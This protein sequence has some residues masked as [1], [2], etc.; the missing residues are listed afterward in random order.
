MSGVFFLTSVSAAPAGRRLH[1]SRFTPL[2]TAF[3]LASILATSGSTSVAQGPSLVVS[4]ASTQLAVGDSIRVEVRVKGSTSLWGVRL[5]LSFDPTILRVSDADRQQGGTQIERGAILRTREAQGQLWELVNR[6][7]NSRGTI[8]YAF[9]LLN[10]ARQAVRPITEEGPLVVVTVRGEA[11]GTS[12]VSFV[13]EDVEL[14]DKSGSAV[15]VALENG[16]V[17]VG[18][19]HRAYLPLTVSQALVGS[20]SAGQRADAQPAV[21]AAHRRS[22]AEVATASSWLSDDPAS[23]SKKPGLGTRLPGSAP[24]SAASADQNTPAQALAAPS[25]VWCGWV[26]TNPL[27]VGFVFT[28]QSVGEDEFL[29]ERQDP[30]ASFRQVGRL[31][32]SA[33]AGSTLVYRDDAIT[34]GTYYRYRVRAH[35]VSDGAYS[36]FSAIAGTPSSYD[37]LYFRIYYRITDCPDA[38]GHQVCVPDKQNPPGVN[39]TAIRVANALA[40]ARTSFMT[41]NGGQG[42]RDPAAESVEP[43]HPV[44]LIYEDGGGMAHVFGGSELTKFGATA[45]APE[46]MDGVVAG[47]DHQGYNPLTNSGEI[48]SWL[49]PL[50]ELFHQA[51][52]AYR[53]GELE[54]SR[55]WFLEGQARSIQ[56]KFCL[57]EDPSGG[58]CPSLD[59]EGLGI[60]SY[61]GEVNGYLANANRNLTEISYAAALFWTYVTE[62]YGLLRQEPHLGVDLIL[63]F[64]EEGSADPRQDGITTLNRALAAL[65]HRVTFEDVFKDFV[66]ANYA[67]ELTGAGVPEKY[68]YI[69]E[70]QPP[71]HY[72]PV[73]LDLDREITPDAAVD[74]TITEVASWGA[75]YYQFRPSADVPILNIEFRQDVERHVYYALLAVKNDGIAFER[76]QTDGDLVEV[77]PNDGYDRVVVIVA[78]LGNHANYRFAVNATRPVLRIL[79]PTEGRFAAAGDPAAPGKILLKVEVLSP[80]GA[81]APLEGIAA[82][83][84]DV[85]IGGKDL[86]LRMGRDLIAYSYIAGQ[87]WLTLRAPVQAADGDYDLTVSYAGSL[88]DTEPG[89]VH[90]AAG[91]EADSLI[92]IDRSLSMA[93]SGKMADAASAARL[94]VDSWNEGDQLGVVSFSSSATVDWALSPWSDANR[95]RALAAIDAIVPTW[96][97]SIGA[98]LRAAQGELDARGIADHDWALLVL[99]DGIE[100]TAPYIDDSLSDWADRANAGQHVPVVHTVAIG[101]DAERADLQNLS[102]T[103]GGLYLYAAEPAGAAAT[104]SGGVALAQANQDLANDLAEHFRTVSA[105]VAGLQQVYVARG[106]SRDMQENV[107]VV[108]T[109]RIDPGAS[110]A[111]FSVNWHLEGAQPGDP[112]VKLFGPQGNERTP[113]LRDP[114]H[115]VVYRIP[116]PAAGDWRLEVTLVC[117]HGEFC[118]QGKYLAEAAVKTALTA[119]LAIGTPAS[120]LVTG[121]AVPLLVTIT[122]NRAITGATVGYTIQT[123]TGTSASGRLYDDGRH[124]DGFANDGVYGVVFASTRDAGSYTVRFTA[125][126]QRTGGAAFRRVGT[127]SFN[128]REGADVDG[129]GLPDGYERQHGLDPNRNDAGEDPDMDGLA[130]RYEYMHHTH[131]RDDDTDN[132][133]ENDGSE[134]D[135]HSDPLDRSDDAIKAPRIAAYPGVAKAF[136]R[137]SVPAGTDHLMLYRSTS[138]DSGY[139]RV[140]SDIR[141]TGIY[142]DAGL[143]NGTAYWYRMVAVGRANQESAPSE[144]SSTTARRDSVPPVGS[145]RINGGARTT[146]SRTVTLDLAAHDPAEPQVDVPPPWDPTSAASGVSEMMLANSS[147]FANAQWEPYARSKTWTIEPRRGRA[148]VF[149]RYRD[150]G[151]NESETMHASIEYARQAQCPRSGQVQAVFLM[152]TS[153]SMD[154]EYEALCERVDQVV[155]DLRGQG[156]T[157]QYDTLGITQNKHCATRNVAALFPTS[158][159]NTPEDWGQAVA[160]VAALYSW[161]EGY[162]RLLVPMSDEGPQDGDPVQDPGADRDVLEAAITSAREQRVIVSPVLGTVYGEQGDYAVTVRLATELAQGTGGQIFMSTAPASDLAAGIGGL[163]GA[164]ACTPV[165]SGVQP[166]CDVTEETVVRVFGQNLLA[167]STVQV[168]GKSARDAA[169]GQDPEHISFRIPTGLAH[170]TYDVTVSNPGFGEGTLPAALTVGP[171]SQRCEGSQPDDIWTPMWELQD[172]QMDLLVANWTFPGELTVGVYSAQGGVLAVLFDP[173][174]VE[175]GRVAV[176]EGAT[177]QIAI[178]LGAATPNAS[179]RLSI[180][181]TGSVT[182]R[183]RA[184]FRGA[185]VVALPDFGDGWERTDGVPHPGV[186]SDHGIESSPLLGFYG[187]WQNL[188]GPYADTTWYFYVTGPEAP[189]QVR[190]WSEHPH[191]DG[192]GGM[193]WITP[194]DVAI[195]LVGPEP[196]GFYHVFGASQPQQGWWGLRIRADAP[197]APGPLHYSL[198]RV[199]PPSG[200]SLTPDY[201]A[202]LPRSM[203]GPPC[204]PSVV[205]DPPRKGA[206]NS[207]VVP[208]DIVVSDVANLYGAEVHLSFDP[209]HLEVVDAT[210][211]VTSVITP[212][213]FPDPGEGRRLVAQN[214]VDNAQGTIDYAVTLLHPAPAAFGDGVLARVLFRVKQGGITPV[215]FTGGKLDE[216]PVPPLGPRQIPVQARGALVVG[217]DCVPGQTGPGQIDGQVVLQGRNNPAGARVVAPPWTHPQLTG[218]DG[219]YSI[220]PLRSA[221]YTVVITHTGYLRTDARKVSVAPGGSIRMPLAVLLGGDVNGDGRIALLDAVLI[222]VGYTYQRGEVEYREAADIDA[223]GVIDLDDLVMVGANWAC[224]VDDTTPRCRRW[225]E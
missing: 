114:L 72:D 200:D 92:V 98:G 118:F 215:R 10:N 8:E 189:L 67:K 150:A 199:S 94:Y 25:D 34:F 70:T 221:D 46:Y 152:D 77:L 33:G 93:D 158:A 144:P 187:R 11:A 129:D 163:I 69:D 37:G 222:S 79:D 209:Q 142:T 22:P 60:A 95:S 128:V 103:T 91:T 73:Y 97:T 225:Q 168:G 2:A 101:P 1:R 74:P 65:G 23:A 134:V 146:E 14:F 132:G 62:R 4:P 96:R 49:I 126:G 175:I 159:V 53:G 220:G 223:D 52:Y 206:C 89:A 6:V 135:R 174:G 156:I 201:V 120:D 99:S 181:K 75:R 165:L 149:V 214:H 171:C 193:W 100:N 51:Q 44:E 108:H 196:S 211:A 148:T 141:P 188:G 78:G 145:I 115:H 162:T 119:E 169:R 41:F 197:Y 136:V 28:G 205:L 224:T 111:T 195:P 29:V 218:P 176:A 106:D 86:D 155:A 20:G 109:I 88:S 164:A 186:G 48:E 151:G 15:K 122:D 219:R 81:G 117:Q 212:G 104:T 39:A 19:A 27:N 17:A 7:D 64:W 71:G 185:L 210:R 76:E 80:T 173:Q 21:T 56:D 13:A 83:D 84:F 45:L 180:Q 208:L 207:S 31:A 127:R 131:P 38:N 203:Q 32:G 161:R 121:S 202:L 43:K 66:V 216:R 59:D 57:G 137:F 213:P 140:A 139:S 61:V 85:R 63:R 107:P 183:F 110:A 143:A 116:S 50:H 58:P 90:Y 47:V 55:N 166:K 123:P 170:G 178:D 68:K 112:Q 147:R 198:S 192:H 125:E 172:G 124:G 138:R 5:R 184:F 26:H 35:R 191:G 182:P 179:Y 42:F 190:V 177:E 18:A 3:I 16:V 204:G 154:D 167:G 102:A 40:N 24:G 194:D 105:E 82:R 9:V 113:T 153:S 87:Y 157:V 130:N 160:D 30:G 217:R 133:G 54:P 12:P 36:P